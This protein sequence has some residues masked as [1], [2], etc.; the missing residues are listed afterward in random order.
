MQTID[1]PT[2]G[3]DTSDAAAEAVSPTKA[4]AIREDV[5]NYIK[6]TGDEG[7]TDQE[8][9]EFLGLDGNTER[10][11]R[12]ELSSKQGRIRAAGTRQTQSGRSATVWIAN[13]YPVLP[14]EKDTQ[15]KQVTV[16]HRRNGKPIREF[17]SFV[18]TKGNAQTVTFPQ[19]IAVL[20]GD[21]VSIS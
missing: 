10:P 13:A 17:K 3:T 14:S 21:T 15:P 12:W 4:A 11:R 2:N 1:P 9:Q 6:S 20:S 7:V 16:T 5:F 8:I 19:A 18:Q